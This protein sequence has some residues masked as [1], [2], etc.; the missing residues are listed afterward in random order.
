MISKPRYFGRFSSLC[1]F[2]AGLCSALAG[3]VISNRLSG[4]GALWFLIPAGLLLFLLGLWFRRKAGHSIEVRID[5][6]ILRLDS[7]KARASKRGLVCLVSLYRR[8]KGGPRSSPDEQARI[9]AAK[10]LSYETL[11]FE[12]SNLEPIVRAIEAHPLLQHCWL[13]GT[14]SAKQD[15]LGSI[16][17]LPAFV[18]YLKEAKAVTFEI[19]YGSDYAIPTVDDDLVIKKTYDMVRAIIAEAKKKNLSQ[20]DMVVDVTGGF[21]SM[22][23]GAILGSLHRD[24]DIQIMGTQYD[25]EGLPIGPLFPILIEFEPRIM[26]ER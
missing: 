3:G 10:N 22:P 17:Y 19:H 6:T 20:A 7:E 1:Y 24:I 12:H 16:F 25:G 23:T 9:A 2:L 18:K 15:N 21:R 4:R 11:D 13:I 26:M 5:P 14:T 8:I